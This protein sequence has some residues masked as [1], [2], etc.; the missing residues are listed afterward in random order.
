MSSF[1]T[2]RLRRLRRSLGTRALDHLDPFLLL[3]HFE[4]ADAVDYEAGFPYHPHRGIETVTLV[5]HGQVRHGDSLGHRGMIGATPK[6]EMKTVIRTESKSCDEQV[7]RFAG[8]Q[9]FRLVERVQRES[10]PRVLNHYGPTETT[11][12]CCTYDVDY[13]REWLD[14]DV[15]NL[16]ATMTGA[17][18]GGVLATSVR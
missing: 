12:G 18:V 16:L 15:V 17:L 3:D 9:Q 7:R 10:G 13:G 4:S 14:N 5:R 2:T 8:Q 1:P 11:V 6:H